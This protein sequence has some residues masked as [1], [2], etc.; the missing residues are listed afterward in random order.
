[1]QVHRWREQE[2]EGLRFYKATHHAG[3]WTLQSQLKNEEEWEDHD[4]M[5]REDW[6]RLREVLFRKYQRR[7][8]PWKFVEAID[9]ILAKPE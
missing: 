3:R 8:C 6:E 2:E 4:P 7:R 5:K 9:K 1:M